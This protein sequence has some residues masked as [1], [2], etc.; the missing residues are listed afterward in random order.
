MLWSSSRCDSRASILS[1]LGIDPSGGLLV[2]DRV[3]RGCMVTLQGFDTWVNLILLDVLDCDLILGMDLLAEHHA[4]RF[5]C[6]DCYLGEPRIL[7]CA[8]KIQ[9]F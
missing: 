3:C 2:V 5:L 9:Y 6:Q 8:T 1:D 4:F 7:L